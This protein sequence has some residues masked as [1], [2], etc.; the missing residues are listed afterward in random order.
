[1]LFSMKCF[2]LNDFNSWQ[3]FKMTNLGVVVA[4]VGNN[5][6]YVADYRNLKNLSVIFHVVLH[7]WNVKLDI[8]K[9]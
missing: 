6:F 4:I 1:M 3:T 2:A 9:F 7:V 8:L 5:F